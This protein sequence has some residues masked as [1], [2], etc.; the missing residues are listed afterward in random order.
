MVVAQIN[1]DDGPEMVLEKVRQFLLDAMDW[2]EQTDAERPI[3][4]AY[5]AF[6]GDMMRHRAEFVPDGQV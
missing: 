6:E 2:V 5:N 1:H 3:I 4:A